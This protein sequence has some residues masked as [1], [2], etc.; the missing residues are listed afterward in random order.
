[1]E[2]IKFKECNA[3]YAENQPEY[4]PLPVYKKP[5]GTVTSCWKMNLWECFY[6]FFTGK[7]YLKSMTFNKPLQP[8]IMSTHFNKGDSTP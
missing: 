8:I 4:V 3:T 6:V 2:P 1:M 7:I 5:D